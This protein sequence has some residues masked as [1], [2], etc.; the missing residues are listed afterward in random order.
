MEENTNTQTSSDSDTGDSLITQVFPSNLTTTSADE[1]TGE[2]STVAPVQSQN[3]II[4]EVPQTNVAPAVQ[5]STFS[6][7][8]QP[9]TLNST[10]PSDLPKKKSLKILWIS[11]AVILFLFIIGGI[12]IF[13]IAKNNADKI[14][15]NYSK[16]VKSYIDKVNKSSK[17]YYS[18]T[19]LNKELKSIPKPVLKN[20]PL[21][22]TSSKY[23]EMKKKSDQLNSKLEIYE[24]TI[25]TY[26]QYEDFINK[27]TAIN[28]D[29]L[30]VSYTKIDSTNGQSILNTF[31]TKLDTFYDE[32]HKATVP[33]ELEA[34]RTD[35]D[36]AS[37][38]C[39]KSWHELESAYDIKNRA[40]YTS[41]LAKYDS[42]LD[43]LYKA[44]DVL[45]KYYDDIDKKVDEALKD[46]NDQKANIT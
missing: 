5:D 32:I 18:V 36:N 15:V 6:Q 30:K 27:I 45:S 11:L 41:A 3:S 22:T 20:A 4:D 46:I 40:A 14:A 17:A 25:K 13:F 38:T 34:A 37:K 26:A 24:S 43:P 9:S 2:K 23:T 33:K 28:K 19:N 8:S 42:C 44:A 1:S 10:M 16:E 7:N 21:A 31:G 12:S 39:V 29:L 35:L